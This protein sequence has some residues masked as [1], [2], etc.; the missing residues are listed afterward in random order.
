MA[1][2]TVFLVN[3]TAA[4]I[5]NVNAGGTDLPAYSVSTVT[6]TDAEL[7]TLQTA[8]AGV[9]TMKSTATTEERRLA[10]KI[11][12]LGKLPSTATS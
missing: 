7:T 5:S 6:L 12:R 8:N 4:E 11:L 10:S 9:V 3:A 1:N 2:Q